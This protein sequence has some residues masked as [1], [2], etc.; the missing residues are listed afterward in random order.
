MKEFSE[1]LGLGGV[2]FW[3]DCGSLE[4]ADLTELAWVQGLFF[5]FFDWLLVLGMRTG[6]RSRSRYWSTLCR[7]C[8]AL[9]DLND[10]NPA[11]G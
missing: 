7:V 8:L 2:R 3:P 5:F 4:G 6:L 10:D 9:G 11:Y 1:Y